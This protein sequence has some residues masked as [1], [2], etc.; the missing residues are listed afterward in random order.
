MTLSRRRVPLRFALS[1][2]G[3]GDFCPVLIGAKIMAHAG[4]FYQAGVFAINPGEFT[5]LLNG[6]YAVT[7]AVIDGQGRGR[8]AGGQDF[9]EAGPVI[10]SV[11]DQKSK[12][13]SHGFGGRL[14]KVHERC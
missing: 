12:S 2:E 3:L 1:S 7:G 11:N 13:R 10:E 8:L 6:N 9:P 5:A 14:A 4:H